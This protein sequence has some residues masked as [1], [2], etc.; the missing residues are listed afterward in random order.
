MQEFQEQVERFETEPVVGLQ[1][2][3]VVQRREEGLTNKS[4]SSATKTTSDIIKEN[5]F[6]YF[7]GIFLI[8]AILLIAVGSFRDLTFLIVI[9][10]NSVIGIIQEL[11]AKRVLDDLT[12]VGRA[13]VTAVRDGV[14]VE[15]DSEE[16]VLDDM[17][18]LS[19]G[20]QIP[21]DAIVQR[22]SVSVNESLLT[23]ESDEIVKRPGDELLSGS[24]IVSGECIARLE[25]VGTDSYSLRCRRPNP[26]RA[27]SQR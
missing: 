5:V 21:A 11:H 18:I 19:A 22:G 27:N 1:Q 9:T 8:L 12:L 25:Q 4:V 3:Q 23:G 15:V 24:F 14:R 26:K 2:A 6:T 16:L 20:C 7:N 10:A 17:V 13:K